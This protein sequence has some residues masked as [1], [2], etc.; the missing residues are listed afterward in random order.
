M[1]MKLT[2][3]LRE[4]FKRRCEFEYVK[5]KRRSRPKGIFEISRPIDVF[6]PQ[7][8]VPPRENERNAAPDIPGM[9]FIGPNPTVTMLDSTIIPTNTLGLF[10][11]NTNQTQKHTRFSGE[12]ER[13]GSSDQQVFHSSPEA[14]SLQLSPVRSRPSIG[15]HGIEFNYTT[16]MTPS[17]AARMRRLRTIREGVPMPHRIAT[18]L[19]NRAMSPTRSANQHKYQDLGGF[20]GPLELVQMAAKRFAPK[21]YTRMKRNLT[22]P[23]TT[24]IGSNKSPWLDFDLIV[25]RNSD[26]PLKR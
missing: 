19:T 6:R 14:A 5:R 2:V 17:A 26:F 3:N 20:P 24:T 15:Q 1:Y 12:H 9:N 16:S 10:D 7:E 22:M 8:P 4:Y 18:I 13:G 21:T 11:D 23:Y 25:G